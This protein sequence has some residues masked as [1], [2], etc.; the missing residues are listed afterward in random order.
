MNLKDFNSMPTTPTSILK[1]VED[2]MRALAQSK[3][4]KSQMS[5]T[6]PNIAQVLCSLESNTS[7]SVG[8]QSTSSGHGGKAHTGT[9]THRPMT[10]VALLPAGVGNFQT[11]NHST[12]VNGQSQ[13]SLSNYPSSSLSY[14][15]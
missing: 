5:N 14:N 9:E 12:L 13:N 3:D 8:P 6:C 4:V 7:K 2:Q 10:G 11:I 15:T 1:K